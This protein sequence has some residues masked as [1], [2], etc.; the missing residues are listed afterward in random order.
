MR[1]WMAKDSTKEAPRMN[2]LDLG[3]RNRLIVGIANEHSLAWSAARQFRAGGVGFRFE[4]MVFPPRA[5]RR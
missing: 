3:E 5:R 1:S 2:I 4:G